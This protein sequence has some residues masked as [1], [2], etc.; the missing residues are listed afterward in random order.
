MDLPYIILIVAG[1]VA[2]SIGIFDAVKTYKATHSARDAV[3]SSLGVSGMTFMVAA[4]I[5]FIGGIAT[6][7]VL[8][9]APL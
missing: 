6:H 8:F 7:F 2:F 9:V 3:A 1:I 5:M 4:A